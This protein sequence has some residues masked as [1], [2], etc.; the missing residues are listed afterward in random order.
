MIACNIDDVWID[1]PTSEES[2]NN[3]K[4]KASCSA[5]ISYDRMYRKQRRTERFDGIFD[6][7]SESDDS[8]MDIVEAIKSEHERLISLMLFMWG[9][10]VILVLLQYRT[11]QKLTRSSPL[12]SL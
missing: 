11:I 10:M 9:G 6:E 1:W 5:K 8:V 2:A 7:R 3:S 12:R 4:E